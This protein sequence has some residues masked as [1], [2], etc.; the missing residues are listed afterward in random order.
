MNC[1]TFW[2]FDTFHKSVDLPWSFVH[3]QTWLHHCTALHATTGCATVQLCT[4]SSTI[5]H[6][7]ALHAILPWL[8]HGSPLHGWLHHSVALTCV[9]SCHC[10]MTFMPSYHWL[11]HSTALCAI[12]CCCSSLTCHPTTGC[13]SVQPYEPFYHWLHCHAVLHASATCTATHQGY[14]SLRSP[15]PAPQHNTCTQYISCKS[16]KRPHCLCAVLPSYHWLC[17]CTLLCSSLPP[18]APFNAATQP[19]MPSHHLLPC[20][21]SLSTILP[22]VSLQ[23]SLVCHPTT[24]HATAMLTIL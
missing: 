6:Y 7:S 8:H 2:P 10:H 15:F 22:P 13:T 24:S 16:S 20:G 12:Q 3:H 14:S 1:V 11:H 23:C 9:P 18:A 4:P 19:C 5:V 21:L 17:H